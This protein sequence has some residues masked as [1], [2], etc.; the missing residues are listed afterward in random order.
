M[1]EGIDV[2]LNV[3]FFTNREYYENISTKI[4]YTGKIDEFFNYCYGELEYRSLIFEEE[5]IKCEDFQGNA[6]IN[7]TEEIIPYTRIVEHKHFNN[8][9]QK[10]TIITREYSEKYI[11]NKN[12]PFYPINNKR[13]NEL[14]QK[15]KLL[16]DKET[17]V[18][19][20]GRL[21]EYKYYN[22]DEIIKKIIN[23]NE[24]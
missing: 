19:F 23:N 4:L 11:K 20:G 16:S 10:N 8:L 14:Y 18:F 12:I 2:E 6:V 13:N 3:D 15:Y 7:Y 5:N 24:K 17:K 21:A 1:L 9:N 22:M